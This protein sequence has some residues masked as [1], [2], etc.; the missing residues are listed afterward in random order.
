MSAEGF[1]FQASVKDNDG[2]MVNVRAD[3]AE[4][5]DAYLSNFPVAAYAQF[6]ANVRG[7]AALGVITQ[8]QTRPSLGPGAPQPPAQQ[9]EQAPAWATGQPPQQAAPQQSGG[10]GAAQQQA[11]QQQG[12]GTSQY[13]NQLHPEGKQC[14]TCGQVLEFGKTKTGKGQWKCG[15]YRWNNGNPNNHTLEWAN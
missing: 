6:K 1:K 7:G 3:S 9:Q 8:P 15:Q 5:L 4:E 14:D 11:P 2:D 10:W 12:G 13:G